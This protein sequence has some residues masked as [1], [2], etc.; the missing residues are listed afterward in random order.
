MTFFGRTRR[1]LLNCF[2]F[3]RN[4]GGKAR[5]NRSEEL[6]YIDFREIEM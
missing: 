5:R 1:D 3:E 2:K 6:F 4:R